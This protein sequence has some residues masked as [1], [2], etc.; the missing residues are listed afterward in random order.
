M[1]VVDD[2]NNGWR[3][4][5]LPIARTEQVIM[6][7]VLAASAFHL[8]GR[9][10]SQSVADPHRLYG[11]AIREL[12]QMRD[13]TGCNK[14]TKQVIILAIVVLLVAVMINGCSDFPIIFQMLESALDA[15]GGE[16]GLLDGGEM[17]SF[18]LRQIRK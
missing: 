18:S 8:T 9:D 5:I 7:A 14:R 15:V 2:V 17:A 1:V 4:L 10:A 3:Y 13:L 11:R 12:Q 16:N 6:S